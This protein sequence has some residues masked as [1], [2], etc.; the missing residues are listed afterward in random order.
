MPF[1]KVSGPFIV[2][3]NVPVRPGSPIVGGHRTVNP[4]SVVRIDS[5]ELAEDMERRGLGVI[6][7]GPE[8]EAPDGPIVE[9]Q[10]MSHK[11]RQAERAISPA[12]RPGAA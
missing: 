2:G 7:P 12:Q 9:R 1:V 3:G 11:L 6:H 10:D 4:G 5:R 8:F